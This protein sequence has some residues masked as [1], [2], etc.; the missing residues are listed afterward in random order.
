M[1]VM[2][3][4]VSAGGWRRGEGGVSVF[5]KCFEMYLCVSEMNLTKNT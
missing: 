4:D 2:N 5:C 3:G 1:Q